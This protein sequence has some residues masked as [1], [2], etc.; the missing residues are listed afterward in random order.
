MTSH[1]APRPQDVLGTRPPAAGPRARALVVGRRVLVTG[2]AGTLGAALARRLHALGPAELHLLDV[3]AAGLHALHL[4]LTGRVPD[5]TSPLH[6]VD[7][8]DARAL[9][10]AV[11]RAEPHLV[12][13][14]AAPAHAA[15]LEG[16]C[17][18]AVTGHVWGTQNVV[19]VTARHRVPRL[20]HVSGADAAHP[21]CVLGAVQRLAEQVVQATGGREPRGAGTLTSSVR[22][23]TLLGGP[24]SLWDTLGHQV[25]TGLPVALDPDATRTFLAPDEAAAHVLEVA[26]LAERPGTYVVDAGTR[27]RAGELV[28]RYAQ[29]AGRP[30]PALDVVGEQPDEPLTGPDERPRAT[31]L[32][33]VRWCPPPPAPPGFDRAL[34][35]LYAAADDADDARVRA[36]LAQRFAGLDAGDAHGTGRPD[37]VPRAPH[38]RTRHHGRRAADDHVPR[39]GTRPVLR[40]VRPVPA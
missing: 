8:R 28:A 23:G 38:D 2:A 36:L 7:V 20:L 25:A 26:A 32:E 18:A 14:A 35:E 16:A 4:A 31:A 27:L 12:V 10:A 37:D 13:H 34:A 39:D 3:D 19:Q 33:G 29:A 40:L 15:L 17:A 1:P 22:L 24:G 30:V 5:A 11:R 6:L 9:D 21:S